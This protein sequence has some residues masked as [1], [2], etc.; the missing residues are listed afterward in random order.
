MIHQTKQERKMKPSEINQLSTNQALRIFKRNATA[1]KAKKGETIYIF[2]R[3]ENYPVYFLSIRKSNLKSGEFTQ[4]SFCG[5][6]RVLASNETL[7]ADKV[8]KMLMDNY[9]F[10]NF[11]TDF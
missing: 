9:N 10:F 4:T 2:N 6:G 7:A 11:K 8:K 1:R 3:G 5:Y